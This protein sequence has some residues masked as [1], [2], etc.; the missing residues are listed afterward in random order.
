MK[1]EDNLFMRAFHWG[2]KE[3]PD[4][5]KKMIYTS[6]V[7][8]DNN[9]FFDDLDELF[10]YCLENRIQFPNYVWCT[11]EKLIHIDADYVVESACE[12]CHEDA[13]NSIDIDAIKD[14]QRILDAWCLM[15]TGTL[16]FT[17]NTANVI[18]ISEDDLNDFRKKIFQ[19]GDT[20][21]IKHKMEEEDEEETEDDNS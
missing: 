7:N 8:G 13:Y 11:S 4:N 10:T 2:Y 17:Q 1:L 5:L 15:Q 3:C 19:Q 6:E 12:D 20:L 16:T 21:I 18:L 14:L 9:G